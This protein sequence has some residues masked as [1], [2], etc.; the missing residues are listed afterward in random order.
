[1]GQLKALLEQTQEAAP[2]PA[3]GNGQEQ[4]VEP[5]EQVEAPQGT[6]HLVTSLLCR[7]I[8]RSSATGAPLIYDVLM[9]AVSDLLPYP[10][11]MVAV[12]FWLFDG[13][14]ITGSHHLS[15]SL[16]TPERQLLAVRELALKRPGAYHLSTFDFGVLALPVYGQYRAEVHVDGQFAGAYPFFLLPPAQPEQEPQQDE[17]GADR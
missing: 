15:M 3:G 11:R 1:M 17:E 7:D 10:Q 8:A 4:R 5:V 16:F 14:A 12:S 2:A 9:A 13:P 6:A